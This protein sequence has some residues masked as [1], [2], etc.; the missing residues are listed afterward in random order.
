MRCR[1]IG[2]DRLDMTPMVDVTFLLLI[3]FMV[4]ASFGLHKSIAMD[5]EL[6]DAP[7]I[8]ILEPPE[9][10]EVQ[11]QIDQYGSFF[12]VAPEWS[13]QTP[14]KRR[15]VET[16]KK[17]ADEA[18][19][20]ILLKIEVHETAKLGSLVQAMDAGTIAG[21]TLKVTQVEGF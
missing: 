13:A 15:L 8:M 16:L 20:E 19:Q 3:F 21:C 17:A 7:G 2:R 5:R 4:T 6:V 14:S 11:L 18:N 12:V 9:V 10:T 1:R